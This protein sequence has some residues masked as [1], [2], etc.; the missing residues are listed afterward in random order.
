MRALRAEE[1]LTVLPIAPY[2]LAVARLHAS[3]LA[4]T[5]RTGCIRSSFDLIVAATAGATGRTLLTTDAAA[6]FD[7]LPGVRAEVISVN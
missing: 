1:M 3:L 5:E 4:W 6:R 2:N 7:E